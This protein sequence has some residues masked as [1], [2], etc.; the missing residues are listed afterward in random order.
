MEKYLQPFLPLCI[1]DLVLG[2]FGNFMIILNTNKKYSF[3][4]KELTL[5]N[6]YSCRPDNLVLSFRVKD[7]CKFL[8]FFSFTQGQ[9]VDFEIINSFALKT[10]WR[11]YSFLKT[12]SSIYLT[13]GIKSKLVTNK[14][15]RFDLINNLFTELPPMNYARCG[16]CLTLLGDRIYA[17]GGQNSKSEFN[18]MEYYNGNEWISVKSSRNTIGFRQSIAHKGEIYILE[19]NSNV[20]GPHGKILENKLYIEKYNPE[21]DIWTSLKSLPCYREYFEVISLDNCIYIMGGYGIRGKSKI[22]DIYNS[23]LDQWTHYHH[24]EPF[25]NCTLAIL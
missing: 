7:N 5:F 24:D 23:N 3:D 10:Q 17:T 6:D 19:P 20:F 16:H 25:Y 9:W 8:Q 12:K 4:G 22:I 14:V 1:V 21:T 15:Y 2:Y 18:T 13:G 11:N